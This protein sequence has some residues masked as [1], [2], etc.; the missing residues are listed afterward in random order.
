MNYIIMDE[1]NG[2]LFNKEFSTKEEAL[3]R[4]EIEWGYLTDK[5]KKDRTAFYVLESVNPD[6]EAE[7]HFDGNIIKDFMEGGF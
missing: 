2:D 6:E 4:A 3:R 5:E 7:N 1:K